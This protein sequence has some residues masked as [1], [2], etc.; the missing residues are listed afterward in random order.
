MG[1]DKVIKLFYEFLVENNALFN[2]LKYVNFE[3]LK[4][5]P[6]TDFVFVTKIWGDTD[7]GHDYWSA[8][9][10]KWWEKLKQN[11]LYERD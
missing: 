11:N 10:N 6:L 5:E 9:C 4:K 8:L 2:Y 3:R 1:Q 7:E